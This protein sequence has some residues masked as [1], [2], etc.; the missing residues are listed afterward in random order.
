[1]IRKI[2]ISS[3]GSALAE[4]AVLKAIE[5]AK[6]TGASVVG[7]MVTEPYPLSMY[8]EPTLPGAETAAHYDDEEQQLS[9]QILEPI[10]QAAQAAGVQYAGCSVSSRS[11]GDAIVATAEHEGCDLICMAMHHYLS[12]LGANLDR[13]TTRVLARSKVPVLLCH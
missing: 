7:L 12:L 1:M 3:D 10:K 2:L 5:L 13:I 4:R 8:G 9:Q 11:P 6:V